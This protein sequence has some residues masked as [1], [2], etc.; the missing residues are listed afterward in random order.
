MN[1]L[2]AIFLL[3]LCLMSLSSNY[4]I[5]HRCHHHRPPSSSSVPTITKP[6][7][8]VPAQQPTPRPQ[9]FC[10]I[11]CFDNLDWNSPEF[12]RP[13]LFQCC[14]NIQYKGPNPSFYIA[15]NYTCDS[16][17]CRGYVLHNKFN[18]SVSPWCKDSHGCNGKMFTL[19]E[20]HSNICTQI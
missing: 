8:T 9:A 4:V 12:P 1:L 7:A 10:S 2:L 6:A 14:C 11:I 3:H 13:G 15:G 18:T 20:P 16:Y 19:E 17:G 5:A